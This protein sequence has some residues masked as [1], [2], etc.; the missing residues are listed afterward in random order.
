MS[1][2]GEERLNHPRTDQNPPPRSR[3]GR[4]RL[5]RT[6]LRLQLPPLVIVHHASVSCEMDSG[7]HTTKERLMTKSS[8]DCA[9]LGHR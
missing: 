4:H 7:A 6:R 9:I 2:F 1:R 5:D 3:A 8:S